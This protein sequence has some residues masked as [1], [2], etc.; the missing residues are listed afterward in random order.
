MSHHAATLRREL[1]AQL[2]RRRIIKT[3]AVRRAFL[4]VPRE[5]FVPDRLR[6]GG[7]EAVYKD[8]AIVTKTDAKGGAISSSSQPAIMAVM[9]EALR[10]KPGLRVLEVGAGTGYNSALLSRIVGARGSVTAIDIDAELVAAARS[11][12]RRA[13]AK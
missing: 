11:A 12:L 2:E 4:A 5:R 8:V 3:P 6:Q 7:L 1:V 13:G 10:L 9:L